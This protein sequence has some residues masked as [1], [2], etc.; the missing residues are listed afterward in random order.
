MRRRR[1][2]FLVFGAPEIGEAEIMNVVEVRGSGRLGS[3]PRVG[4]LR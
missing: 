1:E 3:G 2:D 4:G